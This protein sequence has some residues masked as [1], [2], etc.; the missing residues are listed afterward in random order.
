[1][2]ALSKPKNAFPANLDTS[3]ATV[4]AA[5][6][7]DVAVALIKQPQQLLISQSVEGQWGNAT[8]MATDAR[9]SQRL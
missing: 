8:I 1:M 7:A 9:N 3:H 2:T 6:A 5:A 4:A